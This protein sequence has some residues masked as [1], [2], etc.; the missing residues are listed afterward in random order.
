[1][2]ESSTLL[3]HMSCTILVLPPKGNTYTWGIGLVEVLWKI[4]EAIID[5]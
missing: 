5:T 3:T 2:W 1:M 4:V